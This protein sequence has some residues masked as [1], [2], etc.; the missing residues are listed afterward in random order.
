MKYAV[1]IHSAEEGGYWSEVPAIPG[2]C[3]QG[4]TL[5]EVKRNTIEAIEG[6]VLS[7]TDEAKKKSRRERGSRVFA[8]A[9]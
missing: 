5:D 4:E 3:S 6:C 1:V 7:L 8:L 9:V 2:C